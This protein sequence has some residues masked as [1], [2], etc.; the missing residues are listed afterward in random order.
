MLMAKIAKNKGNEINIFDLG[1]LLQ[2]ETHTWQARKSIPKAIRE[3]MTK[4]T[5]WVSGYRRL[6]KKER[7]QPINSVITSVRNYIW[8]EVSLP[9]PIKSCHF[10]ANGITD[11][12]DIKMRAYQKMLKKEV[13]IFAKDYDKW[14]KESSKA[15]KKD[16]LFDKEAYPMNVRER[17]WIEW[18]W[19]D[20]VIPSGVTEEMRQVEAD[21]FQSMMDETRHSCVI[22]MREGFG[23][24]VTHLTD[25]LNGKL[26]GEK[27]RVRPEA[28]EKIDKFFETFKYKNIF[29]DNQLQGLVIQAKDL[30]SDVTPKDLRNDQSLTKLIHNGL[31]DITEELVSST[32]TY[33]RKLTF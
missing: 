26:D 5:D 29:N 4:E 24:L 14:I 7:L 22:A 31:N 1:T 9:F 32:E 33:K 30:L 27:R 16:G 20:M 11:E 8:D 18:R 3:R 23:E 28:L 6:I 21:Q 17:Y 19:F 13:N 25:T 2:F 10:I 15:L 12:V